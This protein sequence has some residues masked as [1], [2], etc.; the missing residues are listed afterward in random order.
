MR[1]GDGEKV[2]NYF[3]TQVIVPAWVN[4]LAVDKCEELYAYENE[5][6]VDKSDDC[7]RWY[8]DT[9]KSIFI[10]EFPF[11]EGRWVNSLAPSLNSGNQRCDLVTRSSRFLYSR[12]NII[13][14]QNLPYPTPT[15]LRKRISWQSVFP[16]PRVPWYKMISAG[17]DRASVCEP[18]CG[19]QTTRGMLSGCRF[20]SIF[21]LFN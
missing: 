1:V 6:Y 5:P 18:G 10:G 7:D 11:E 21:S 13:P 9:G 19:F 8:E 14:F 4:W 16:G 2:V 3:G 15:F 17:Q 12:S 20:S